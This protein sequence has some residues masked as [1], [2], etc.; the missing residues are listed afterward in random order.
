MSPLT[1]FF[2]IIILATLG[3]LHSCI[4]FR[5]SLPISAKKKSC[6]FNRD[7]FEY[8]ENLGSISI[9]TVIQSSN[10]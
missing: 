8:V 6:G 3:P 10:P 4:N 1:L 2:F 5:I 9:L 7:G